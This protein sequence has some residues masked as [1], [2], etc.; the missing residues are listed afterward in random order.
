MYV[1]FLACLLAY[2]IQDVQ[3][4]NVQRLTTEIGS[5][6]LRIA[7]KIYL[8]KK[9]S[10]SKLKKKSWIPFQV[11]MLKKYVGTISQY[12]PLQKKL[13]QLSRFPK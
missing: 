1:A 5:A 13:A 8:C 12:C 4:V 11:R 9:Y 2:C 3:S 10:R 7:L 6:M